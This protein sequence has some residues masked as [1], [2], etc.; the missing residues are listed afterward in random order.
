MSPKIQIF[1]EE[2]L[3]GPPEDRAYWCAMRKG[4]LDYIKNLE[5]WSCSD[6]SSY[7]D[8]RIQGVPVKSTTRFKVVPWFELQHYPTTDMDDFEVPF[9]EGIDHNTIIEKGLETRSQED[10][11]IQTINLHNVTFADAILKGALSSKKQEH[12][13]EDAT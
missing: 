13:E 12:W 6:C 1:T 5:M 4:K 2:E 9:A 7:Y 11:R 8:T 10:N 3:E